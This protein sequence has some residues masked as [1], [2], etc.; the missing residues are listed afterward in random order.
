MYG[1]YIY[2]RYI[3]LRYIYLYIYRKNQPNLGKYDTQYHTWILWTCEFWSHVFLPPSKIEIER[4]FFGEE[5]TLLKLY[6]IPNFGGK[7]CQVSGG[8]S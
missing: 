1:T 7:G 8:L 2:L 5:K 6:D 3:Y 4:C